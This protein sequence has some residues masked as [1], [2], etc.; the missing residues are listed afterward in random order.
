MQVKPEW[1]PETLP[2]KNFVE[3]SIILSAFASK[4]A[5]NSNELANKNNGLKIHLL[6]WPDIGLHRRVR[7]ADTLS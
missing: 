2:V 3:N 5:N 7:I 6:H 4:I 1:M